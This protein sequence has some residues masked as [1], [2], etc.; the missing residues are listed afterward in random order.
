MNWIKQ[1]YKPAHYIPTHNITFMLV[2][3]YEKVPSFHK[4]YIR[5][6]LTVHTE[7]ASS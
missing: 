4:I 1:T 2:T 7:D 3:A 6:R 5:P